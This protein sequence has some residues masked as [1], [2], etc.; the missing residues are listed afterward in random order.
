MRGQKTTLALVLIIAAALIIIFPQEALAFAQ[1]YQYTD[2]DP[3]GF[4]SGV[5]NGLLAPWALIA[6]WFIQDVV[7]YATP[8]IGWL[9]DLGFL[10]G[11]VGSIP[12]GWF[13]AILSAL[14]HVFY[15]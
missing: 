14:Y 6:Y 10:I 15:L 2:A 3:A 5:W 9:Y 7:M 11:I 4:F 13:L 8:N 1:K 12:I